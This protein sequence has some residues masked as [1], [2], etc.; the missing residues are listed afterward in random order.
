MH[1]GHAEVPGAAL[2]IRLR[3]APG[4]EAP[5]RPRL[6]RPTEAREADARLDRP[7]AVVY[8]RRDLHV[9]VKALIAAAPHIRQLPDA[10]V[11]H[12][13]ERVHEEVEEPVAGVEHKC[14][15]IVAPDVAIAL[16]DAPAEVA[17]AVHLRPQHRLLTAEPP[18]EGV[19]VAAEAHL[20]RVISGCGRVHA[21][22]PRQR[23]CLLPAG[24][25]AHAIERR[26][27][28]RA[29][30]RQQRRVE[31]DRRGGVKLLGSRLGLGREDDRVKLGLA[32]CVARPEELQ[33][34]AVAHHRGGKGR[35]GDPLP[36]ARILARERV[37]ALRATARVHHDAPR[38]LRPREARAGEE[39]DRAARARARDA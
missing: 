12:R 4:D 37:D 35:A 8:G 33:A 21:R 16:S 6:R 22:E 28:L 15:R 39:V 27:R 11:V 1:P 38:G 32:R 10:R 29:P 9:R 34:E 25:I 30:Y 13:A 5:A 3:Y 20:G 18:V 7:E 19:I 26:G 17:D 24:V 2:A 14:R 31:S 36:L 23:H